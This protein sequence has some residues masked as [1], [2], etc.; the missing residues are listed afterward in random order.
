M[1][2]STF[3]RA[4]RFRCSTFRCN[5][6]GLLRF[7]VAVSDDMENGKAAIGADS[8]AEASEDSMLAED[9]SMGYWYGRTRSVERVRPCTPPTPSHSGGNTK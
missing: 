8:E 3:R 5:L 9:I 1:D 6:S 4:K 7:S 2:S